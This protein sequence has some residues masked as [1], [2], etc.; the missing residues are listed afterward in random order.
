[1]VFKKGY[2]MSNETKGI[3]YCAEF[4]IKS[5]SLHKDILKEEI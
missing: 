1:M 3:T 5:K 2:L 4:H